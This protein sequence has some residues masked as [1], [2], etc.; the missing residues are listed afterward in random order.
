MLA[1]PDL[2]FD[3]DAHRHS[4]AILQPFARASLLCI[5]ILEDD[6]GHP[7]CPVSGCHHNCQIS[8]HILDP[9]PRKLPRQLLGGTHHIMDLSIQVCKLSKTSPIPKYLVVLKH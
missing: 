8:T 2:V 5:L 9:K 3:S 6:F 7:L 4:A 1:D